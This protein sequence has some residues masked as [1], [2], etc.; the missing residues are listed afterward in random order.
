MHQPKQHRSDTRSYLQDS[1]LIYISRLRLYTGE[2]RYANHV[3]SHSDVAML[4]EKENC[5]GYANCFYM[6]RGGER[7]EVSFA[8]PGSGRV[9]AAGGS[10]A[11]NAPWKML[12]FGTSNRP[13]LGKIF[14][15]VIFDSL[16]DYFVNNK[17]LTPRQSG[18]I[19]G[20][21]ID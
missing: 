18:F 10:G 17:P 12:D 14:E 9:K 1:L 19:K 2:S 8:R 16:Y 4:R 21:H 6:G 20:E 3:A 5:S 7:H 15:K 11:L 13:I